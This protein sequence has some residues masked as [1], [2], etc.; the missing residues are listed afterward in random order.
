MLR[1]LQAEK[2][3]LRL[4]LWIAGDST[5]DVTVPV[6]QRCERTEV[7]PRKFYFLLRY[8]DKLT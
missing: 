8:I 1:G 4:A 7:Y 5:H 3:L 6:N 2:P